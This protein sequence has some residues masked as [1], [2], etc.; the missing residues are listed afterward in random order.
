MELD[1]IFIL[2]SADAPEGEHLRRAGLAEGTPNRHPGQGTACRRFLFRNAYIELLW[3]CDALEAQ[4][5]AVRR[6]QLWDRWM[7][8]NDGACPFGVILRSSG[9]DPAA[10]FESWKYQPPYLPAP[11]AIDV[12]SDVPLT[13]PAFF[14]LPFP[15]APAR[16]ATSDRASGP[17]L[18]AATHVTIAGPR[19]A[20]SAAA[21]I[22]EY[23]GWLTTVGDA[24]RPLMTL[25]I[26]DERRG[27]TVDLRPE[28]PLILK[29]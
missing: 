9:S 20:T 15:R 28:L 6:T 17:I 7:A 21:R 8:R 18:P 16:L 4:T 10:P 27:V 19:P 1:H 5:D 22:V 26:D 29:W 13:E 25:I 2:V 23:G 24:P 11:H 14:H 12:A 3:V